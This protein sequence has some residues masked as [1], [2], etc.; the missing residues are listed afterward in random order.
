MSFILAE[1]GVSLWIYLTP[2]V[3]SKLF[4]YAIEILFSIC[5]HS[6]RSSGS[7]K[8]DKQYCIA[9]YVR[10]STCTLRSDVFVW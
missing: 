4:P 1:L 3:H 5:F 9:L 7:G 2:G 8:L 10:K 6:C